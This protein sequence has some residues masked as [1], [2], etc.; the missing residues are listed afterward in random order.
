[1]LTVH[2]ARRVLRAPALEMHLRRHRHNSPTTN[3]R[4]G[5]SRLQGLEDLDDG[6]LIETENDEDSS[7]AG[8]LKLQQHRRV[9]YYWR[10]IEHEIP[11]LVAYGGED[12]PAIRKRT[13]V[14][15]VARLPL[16]DEAAIHKFKLLAGTRWTP[17]PPA[18]SGVSPLEETQEHGYF[19]ISCE[20]FPVGAQNLKWASDA[21]DRLLTEANNTK[22]SFE[23]IPL[24]TRHIESKQRKEA[25]GDHLYGRR[26]VRPSLRDFPKEWLPAV[27]QNATSDSPQSQ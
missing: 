20:D 27:D 4:S 16:K 13:V 10:L 22:D 25:K 19:S 3:T 23:D 9:L 15:P 21:L 1:M 26:R 7:A 18:N 2:R 5:Y 6:L 12:H 11:H 17:E 8:H 24:D 14:V